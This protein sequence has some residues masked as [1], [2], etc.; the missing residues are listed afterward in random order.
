MNTFR[1]I[2]DHSIL[3]EYFTYEEKAGKIFWKVKRRP[4]IKAGDF[5]GFY[6][7]DGYYCVKFNGKRYYAHRLIWMLYHKEDPGVDFEIDHINGDPSDNRILNLR[8]TLKS[9]NQRN[10]KLRKDNACGMKGVSF[11]K[12]KGLYFVQVSVRGKRFKSK[13]CATAELANSIAKG[14]RENL[15]GE[16]TNHG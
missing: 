2:P 7:P 5:A 15:H 9:G 11:D 16:F 13:G 3:E 1:P 14:W 12:S 8:V 6:R 10:T 4:N